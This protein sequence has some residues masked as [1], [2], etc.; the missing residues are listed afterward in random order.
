MER[1]AQHML[2]VLEEGG[3]LSLQEWNTRAR[4]HGRMGADDV[5]RTNCYRARKHLEQQG[6]VTCGKDGVWRVA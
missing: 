4:A 3:G 5:A 2:T 6:H 1:H